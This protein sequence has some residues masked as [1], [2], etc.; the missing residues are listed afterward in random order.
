MLAVP[1]PTGACDHIAFIDFGCCGYLPGP[2]RSTLMM[3][4]SAFA[5][6]R[7]D[8]RQFT[9]GFAHALERIEGLGDAEKLDVDT[10]SEDM[11]PVLA[12]LRRLNPFQGAVD[13]M[14]PEL[15]MQ[16][17]RLQ[18]VLCQHGVQL[19]REFTLLIKTGCFGALYFSLLDEEHRSKLLSQLLVAGAAHAASH[20]KDA[21]Q[22]LS[23]TTLATLLRA[24]RHS[25][26]SAPSARGRVRTL[27]A[28]CIAATLPALVYYLDLHPM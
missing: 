15:H 11:K 26:M 27:T 24:L 7:P 2:L 20:P 21:R 6:K 10:L 19:P 23:P 16:L 13:P 9:Q 14:D 22:L 18:K 12:E 3:Q 4:A 8:V 25:E 17:F 5:G 28:L 1:G